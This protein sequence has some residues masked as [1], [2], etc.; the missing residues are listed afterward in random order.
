MSSAANLKVSKCRRFAILF[1][2]FG[3]YFCIWSK[4]YAHY[5]LASGIKH[6]VITSDDAAILLHQI[7]SSDLPDRDEFVI[8]EVK[9]VISNLNEAHD[10]I[11]GFELEEEMITQAID[12]IEKGNPPKVH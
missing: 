8:D 5:M 6:G 7:D 3:G 1:N 9:T 10:E 12:F 2:S 4:P 11:P